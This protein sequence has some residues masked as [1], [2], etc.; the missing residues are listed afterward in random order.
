MSPDNV[1]TVRHVYEALNRD[2]WDAAYRSMHPDFDVTFQRGPNAGTHQ[3]RE[4]I[5]KVL[6]DQRAAFAAWIIEPVRLEK[7]DDEVV[8]AVIRSRLR[9]HGAAAEF[10][11]RNG[12]L[13]TI[14]DGV[15]MS[16]RGFPNPEDAILAAGLSD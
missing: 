2:D 3:G 8:L 7:V 4:Q 13:W 15:V 12:H 5:Q 9:P 6:Q 1:E 10:E 14:R 16:L 11:T